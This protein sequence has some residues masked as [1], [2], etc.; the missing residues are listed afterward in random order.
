MA[1][2]SKSDVGTKI[3]V[4]SYFDDMSWLPEIIRDHFHFESDIEAIVKKD[5]IG[6]YNKTHLITVVNP[7][8]K[9]EGG[10]WQ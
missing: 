8:V 9:A 2:L 10:K 7:A 3:I 4:R 5:R 1:I 6:I